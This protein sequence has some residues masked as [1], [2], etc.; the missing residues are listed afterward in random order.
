ME[1]SPRETQTLAELARVSLSGASV[2]TVTAEA[3]RSDAM[4]SAGLEVTVKVTA[5]RYGRPILHIAPESPL[6]DRIAAEPVVTVTVAAQAP[7]EALALRGPAMPVKS[8]G[9]GRRVMYR[10]ALLGV[11]FIRPEQTPVGLAAFHAAQ[12]DQLWGQG[13]L[14]LDHLE[15]HHNKELESCVRAHGMPEAGAVVARSLDRRGL[16]LAVLTDDGVSAVWM[17]FLNGPVNSPAE[18]AWQLRL[19]LTCRCRGHHGDAA[20]T[21]GAS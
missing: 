6:V 11:D 10:V 4:S 1:A 13:Q 19:C 5:D 15:R 2:A 9:D 21:S 12:P 16:E 20:G 8:C 14:M 18:L 7:Y 3:S 17:P